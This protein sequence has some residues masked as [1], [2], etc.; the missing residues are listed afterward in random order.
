MAA[1]EAG[2]GPG[3]HGAHKCLRS[4][5]TPESH[6]TSLADV[7]S[8]RLILSVSKAS[9][10]HAEAGLGAQ[11]REGCLPPRPAET[12]VAASFAN[13][14]VVRQEEES[15]VFATALAI[16]P[17]SQVLLTCNACQHRL[18]QT[19][20]SRA[21]PRRAFPGDGSKQVRGLWASGQ[22]RPSPATRLPG[23]V[24][25]ST[26]LGLSIP[27]FLKTRSIPA[28]S[29]EASQHPGDVT[30]RAQGSARP[31]PSPTASGFLCCVMLGEW[32]P[33][34]GSACSLR[35]ESGSW[36]Q[37]S[38][39]APAAGTQ[40]LPYLTGSV[41]GGGGQTAC[42]AQ[43]HAC[44]PAYA[45]WF[46]RTPSGLPRPPSHLCPGPGAC[47]GLG[48]GRGNLQVRQGQGQ[49]Y[50]RTRQRGRGPG[51]SRDMRGHPC[52]RALASRG[53]DTG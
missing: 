22:R 25:G 40:A 17:R 12:E 31:L 5:C 24:F 30:V 3:P 49:V 32:A 8:V 23:R 11:G 4:G 36:G 43:V 35:N 10:S 52:V 6:S 42:W 26:Y 50:G 41:G 47:I 48:R 46:P 51:F 34:L 2:V 1:E 29:T 45:S 14:T 13:R 7:T 20:L 38:E 33:S 27:L 39:S 19:S 18:A 9:D 21:A 37:G 44:A 15:A 28:G 53:S 16:V